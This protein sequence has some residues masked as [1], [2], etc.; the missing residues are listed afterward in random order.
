MPLP[1]PLNPFTARPPLRQLILLLACFAMACIAHAT[2]QGISKLSLEE[3]QTRRHEIE[4]ELTQLA[5]FNLRVGIGSICFRSMPQSSEDAPEWVQIDFDKEYEIDQV[6]LVPAIWRDNE[7]GYRDD[8]FPTEFLIVAGN[9]KTPHG[10][11]IKEV[12]A[13]PHHI[14]RVAPL[15]IPLENVTASWVRIESKKL[16]PRFHDGSY[17]LQFSEIMVF[18]ESDNVALNQ[19]VS[20]SSEQRAGVGAAYRRANLVDG[21]LP[22]IMDAAQGTKSN[23]YLSGIG[24]G[25]TSSIIFDLVD[26]H[27]ITK[28]RIHTIEQADT[29]PHALQPNFALPKRFL[30]EG[31][32]NPDFS[33]A[34]LL[35]DF[36][37]EDLFEISPIITKRIEASPPVRY[38]RLRQIEPFIFEGYADN[39]MPLIGTRIGFAEVE[40][41]SRETNVA[42]G[43]PVSSSFNDPLFERHRPLSLATDGHNIFGE[44]LGFKEWLNQLARRHDLQY[45]LPF[46]NQ[47]IELRVESQ[48]RNLRIWTWSAV[49]FATLA[50]F[51][52]LI[53]RILRQRAIYRTRERIAA[54]LHDELGANLHAIALL[55]DLALASKDKPQKSATYV[56]RI[57][58]LVRRTGAAVKRCTNMLETKGLYQDLPT[59]MKQ[60]A[61]RLMPDLEHTLEIE[62][63]N[64]LYKVKQRKRIDLFLF[65]KESLINLLRH[66]NATQARSKLTIT[67]K[68]LSIEIAD[69]GKGLPAP[70]ASAPPRSLARRARLIGG[71]VTLSSNETGGTSIKLK[72]NL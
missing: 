21:F 48:K 30:F 17:I 41:F 71:K 1:F 63:E 18:S 35:W 69:N 34:I 39:G 62:G 55:G 58:V 64:F 49:A 31:A 2:P 51:I 20:S 50:V 9:S 7:N 5:N 37:H 19:R 32:N 67:S 36:K 61:K 70:H 11:I 40:I 66:S 22:Y 8:G 59:E 25:E 52:F 14:P 33:D 12:K 54:D 24:I 72:M 15:I 38:I 28:L 56:E 42:K 44:I 27:P 43:K 13:G 53:D 4:A 29:V 45:E 60:I 10:T 23:P 3:L 47:A 26:A 6:A 46:I 68:D 16:T 57:R 65:Y